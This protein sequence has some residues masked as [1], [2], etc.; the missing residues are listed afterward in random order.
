MNRKST[1]H[2]VEHIEAPDLCLRYYPDLFHSCQASWYRELFE[3]LPWRQEYAHLFGKTMAVPRLVAW[4]ASPGR[5]YRYSGIVHHGD[6]WSPLMQTILTR[7]EAVAG[8]Q[9]NS[10]LANLYRDGADSMGWHADDE[11]ELGP[12]PVVASLSLGAERRFSLRHRDRSCPP[13]SMSL[14]PGSLL[15]MEAG[16]QRHWQHQIPKTRRQVAPRINLSFRHIL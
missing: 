3:S 14:A 16:C 4:M 7:V 8:Q 15:I 13:I 9:F 12:D 1:E 2:R 11:P 5:S 6:G 10:V